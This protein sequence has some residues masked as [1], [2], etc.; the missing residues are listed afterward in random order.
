MRR[1]TTRANNAQNADLKTTLR[2]KE[3]YI[4]APGIDRSSPLV[5]VLPHAAYAAFTAYTAYA[6]YA[7]RAAHAASRTL[8]RGYHYLC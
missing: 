6:A 3:I 4:L 1:A 7:T 8:L 5:I 2:A